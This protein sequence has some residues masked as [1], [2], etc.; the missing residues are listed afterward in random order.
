M[1]DSTDYIDQNLP[2]ILEHLHALSQHFAQ[3]RHLSSADVAQLKAII[4]QLQY[5]LRTSQLDTR[6]AGYLQDTILHLENILH[7]E[8]PSFTH[9]P[10]QQQQNEDLSQELLQRIKQL[11]TR[12]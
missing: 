3:F 9:S 10:K 7:N 1:P 12:K 6:L 11:S 4:D 2:T 5:F 8:H